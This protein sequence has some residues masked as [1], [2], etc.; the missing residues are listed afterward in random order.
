[1]LAVTHQSFTEVNEKNA[2]QASKHQM[3]TLAAPYFTLNIHYNLHCSD[4]SLTKN[5]NTCN[6]K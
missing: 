4:L 1:M 5:F 6:R 3:C 2:L